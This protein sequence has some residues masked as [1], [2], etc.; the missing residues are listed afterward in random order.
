MLLVTNFVSCWIYILNILQESRRSDQQLAG[1][2]DRNIKVIFPKESVSRDGV[3]E[4]MKA[5][6]YVTV[7]VSSF[8]TEVL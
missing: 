8:I 6:D 7:K 1:R 4:E 2:C 3:I 5:G